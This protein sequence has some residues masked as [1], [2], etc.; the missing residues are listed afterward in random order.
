MTEEKT[1]ELSYFGIII[2]TD[3]EGNGSID[4]PLIN[5]RPDGWEE[6]PFH[7]A[8][9]A[10]L[11]VALYHALTGIDVTDER[12]AKGIEQQLMALSETYGDDED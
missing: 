9:D 5:D 8:V 6:D 4:T 10:V 7:V 11:G 12:Y 2:T 3:G 1:F